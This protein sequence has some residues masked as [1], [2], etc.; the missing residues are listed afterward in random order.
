MFQG[1]PEGIELIEVAT[2]IDLERDIL[3]NMG[4]EPIIRQAKYMDARIFRAGPMGLYD[5][6]FSARLKDR[7][8]FDPLNRRLEVNLRGHKITSVH[9]LKA[10]RR[11]IEKECRGFEGTVDLI[12]WYDA[13]TVAPELEADFQDMIAYL[14]KSFYRTATRYTRSPFQRL[15]FGA[16]LA[17]RDLTT[18]VDGQAIV[19]EGPHAKI[20]AE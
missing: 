8:T 17:K 4:F 3:P 11:I 9:D 10:L 12:S 1:T 16:A 5:E 13:F 14:E 20:A 6:I 7:V 2:G 15:R 18:R 19:S